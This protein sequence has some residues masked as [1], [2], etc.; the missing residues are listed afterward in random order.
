MGKASDHC[1]ADLHIHFSDGEHD[2]NYGFKKKGD[3]IEVVWDNN[4]IKEIRNL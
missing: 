4:N 2:D 1:K 3:N